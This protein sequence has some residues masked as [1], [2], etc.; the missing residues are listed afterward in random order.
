[1]HGA[2]MCGSKKACETCWSSK[3]LSK[4]ERRVSGAEEEAR[5][6]GPAGSGEWGLGLKT[7]RADG[8]MNLIQLF[9]LFNTSRIVVLWTGFYI[10]I[11]NS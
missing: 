2:E 6:C 7:R 1:M 3:L 9:G 4:T 11:Y 5:S 8:W 10:K